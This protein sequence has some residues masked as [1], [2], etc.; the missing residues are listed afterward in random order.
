METQLQW[1]PVVFELNQ[2]LVLE[3]GYRQALGEA[4]VDKLSIYGEFYDRLFNERKVDRELYARQLQETSPE[5]QATFASVALGGLTLTAKRSGTVGNSISVSVSNGKGTD[6]V[7]PAVDET[8]NSILRTAA[9]TA[10]DGG[11][12]LGI[13][14]DE[15]IAQIQADAQAYLASIDAATREEARGLLDKSWG[16]YSTA[17]VGL[18]YEFGK[19]DLKTAL[20]TV[21]TTSSPPVPLSATT[22]EEALKFY[23]ER[24]S[25]LKAATSSIFNLTITRGTTSEDLSEIVPGYEIDISKS[26]LIGTAVWGASTRPTNGTYQMAGGTDGASAPRGKISQKKDGEYFLNLDSKRTFSLFDLEEIVSK[27]LLEAYK[28]LQT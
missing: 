1:K 7:V 21:G 10:L 6:F 19:E 16:R 15:T 22:K 2:A 9:D 20:D 8:A 5:V 25:G 14:D 18:D 11:P 26:N 13:S 12:P 17:S 23:E 27:T 3:T 28:W 24:I 4:I